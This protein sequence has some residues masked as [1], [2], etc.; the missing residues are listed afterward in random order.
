M[1]KKII[2]RQETDFSFIN[3]HYAE[4]HVTPRKFGIEDLVQIAGC[5]SQSSS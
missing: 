3:L 1:K 2:K 5:L 4:K